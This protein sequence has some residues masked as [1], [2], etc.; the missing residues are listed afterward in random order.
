MAALPSRRRGEDN[1]R[2]GEDALAAAASSRQRAADLELSDSASDEIAS[3]PTVAG[4]S[5][6]AAMDEVAS[7]PVVRQAHVH[8]LS[9]LAEVPDFALPA[10]CPERDL[11]LSLLTALLLPRA[12]VEDEIKPWSLQSLLAELALDGH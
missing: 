7:A 2:R 4:G 5:G 8:N 1:S 3:I 6:G 10:G 12:A 11:D 9:Q